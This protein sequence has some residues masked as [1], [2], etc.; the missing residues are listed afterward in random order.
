MVVRAKG[1]SR[2]WWLRGWADGGGYK[3]VLM[4]CVG[5]LEGKDVMVEYCG[6]VEGKSVWWLGG[7]R[8][9]W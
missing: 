7:K 2:G 4:S 6:F 8:S 3:S 5:G 9:A 1:V